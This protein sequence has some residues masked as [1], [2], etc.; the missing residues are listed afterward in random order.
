MLSLN[1]YESCA[2]ND[3]LG[4]NTFIF[5]IKLFN[6]YIYIFSHKTENGLGGMICKNPNGMVKICCDKVSYIHQNYCASSQVLPRAAEL[7]DPHVGFSPYAI[8]GE[9]GGTF[10]RSVWKKRTFATHVAHTSF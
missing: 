7:R 5:F 10:A 4:N 8:N 2:L 9:K 3:S 6:T 1:L